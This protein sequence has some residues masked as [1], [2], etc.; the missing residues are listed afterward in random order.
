MMI[1]SFT[2]QECKRN[3]EVLELKIKSLEFAIE[4]SEA[5]INESQLN[6]DALTFLRRQ[7]SESQQDLEILYLIKTGKSI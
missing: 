3:K 2:L 5:M 1:D 4:Q 6:S 7:K